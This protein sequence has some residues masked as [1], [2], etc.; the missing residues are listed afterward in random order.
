[1]N[2]RIIYYLASFCQSSFKKL[3]SLGIEL[4][5]YKSFLALLEDIFFFFAMLGNLLVKAGA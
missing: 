2:I 1:M 4:F 3:A 5:F